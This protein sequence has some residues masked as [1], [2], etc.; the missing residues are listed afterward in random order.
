MKKQ[1]IKNYLIVVFLFSFFS[2]CENKKITLSS[3]FDGKQAIS[4]HSITLLSEEV[5]ADPGTLLCYDSLLILQNLMSQPV[6]SVVDINKGTLIRSWGTVGNGPGEYVGCLQMD[7]SF[8]RGLINI[9]DNFQARMYQYSL[10]SILYSNEVQPNDLFSSSKNKHTKNMY[11]R[12][13]QVNDSIFLGIQISNLG[14]FLVF[15]INSDESY[16]QGEFPKSDDQQKLPDENI[17]MLGDAYQ[18]Y[19]RYNYVQ[20]KVVYASSNSEIVEIFKLNGLHLELEKGYYTSLPSYSLKETGDGGKFLQLQIDNGH[21]IDLS[22]SD[23]FIYVLYADAAKDASFE[24]KHISNLILVFD[25]NGE[26]VKK[27]ILDAKVKAFTVSEDE[28]RIFA[29]YNNPDPEIIY[30]DL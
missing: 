3:Y 10:D 8:Q 29:V 9:P 2:N 30:F 28:K 23:K 1:S 22:S 14:R 4:L 7:L 6:F 21:T 20:N 26:P 13:L 19:L 15:N 16:P 24:E 11:S 17:K 12:I 25:W 18:G 5:T 27:Y